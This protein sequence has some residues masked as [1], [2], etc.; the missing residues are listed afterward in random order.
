MMRTDELIKKI[1]FHDSNVIELFREGGKVRFRIDLCMWKQKEY[2]EGTD[3]IKEIILEFNM[4]T[5]YMWD[6][7]KA[8]SDIDYDTIL[9]LSYNDGVVKIVLEDE[10]ISIVTFKCNDVK[11]ANYV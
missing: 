9:E 6:S 2:K 3:E 8:E 7:S 11:F 1:N 5:D 10:D 4:I